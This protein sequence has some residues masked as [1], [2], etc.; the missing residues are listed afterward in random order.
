MPVLLGGEPHYGGFL[1]STSTIH[2]STR[3]A[4]R[5]G[6]DVTTPLAEMSVSL[7]GL[8]GEVRDVRCLDDKELFTKTWLKEE[9]DAHTVSAQWELE[10]TFQ[11]SERDKECEL[12]ICASP[13]VS[14]QPQVPSLE[15]PSVHHRAAGVWREFLC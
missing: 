13:P 4:L 3:Q 1:L 14:E 2:T 9:G 12:L 8:S 5:M 6:K 7:V 10:E 11:L 15:D